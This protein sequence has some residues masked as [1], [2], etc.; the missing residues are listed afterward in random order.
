MEYWNAGSVFHFAKAI[1]PHHDS[2]IPTFQISSNDS[3]VK[4]L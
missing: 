1:K 4:E 3:G 2:I